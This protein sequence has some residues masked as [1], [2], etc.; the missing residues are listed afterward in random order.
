MNIKA[1][2]HSKHVEGVVKKSSNEQKSTRRPDLIK[3][4]LETTKLSAQ[5]MRL[6]DIE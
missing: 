2:K 4:T 6:L 3:N 1:E 5:E